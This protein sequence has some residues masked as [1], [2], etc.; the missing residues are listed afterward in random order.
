MRFLLM[1]DIEGVTGVTTYEQAER[2]AFGREMLMHD[3]LA[4]IGGIRSMGAHE[5]V[6]YDMHTDGRNV[7]MSRLP[8]DVC[9]VVGKPIDGKTY[10][11]AGG[12]FDG[13][14]LVGLH[15]MSHAPGAMLAHS[16][17]REYDE[18]YL[19]DTLVGEIGVEAALAGE[20]GTPLL[21]VAGDDK[22]CGEAEQLLPGVTTAAVKRSLGPAQALCSTPDASA[23]ILHAAA[24][25]AVGQAKTAAPWKIVL[26]VDLKVRFSDCRYLHVMRRLHPEIFEDA[27]TVHMKG[28]A[29]HPLWSEYLAYE[30][31]MLAEA[32]RSADC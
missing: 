31:E 6:V 4:V 16:Y 10:R 3:L 27:R 8:E 22:G 23:R 7:D 17:L 11:G 15:A 12:K 14:F 28:P 2:S 9:T 13:L 30:Q 29:L 32:L 24:Q 19:N 5:I 26:P 25:R 20:Q 21:F 18:I 1:T